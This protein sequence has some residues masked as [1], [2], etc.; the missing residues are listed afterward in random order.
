MK[1]ALCIIVVGLTVLGLTLSQSVNRDATAQETGSAAMILVSGG[2]F[3]MGN[4]RGINDVAPEHKR[5]FTNEFPVH[6]VT[7]SPYWIGK[8]EVTWPLWVRV[9][10]WAK[11]NGY[12]FGNEG[13]EFGLPQESKEPQTN[14]VDEDVPAFLEINKSTSSELPVVMINWYDMVKWCNAYSEMQGLNPCYYTSSAFRMVY[15]IG[16]KDLTPQFVNWNANGYRLPTEAEWEYA[17]K[18]GVAGAAN[19]FKYAGGDNPNDVAW[20]NANSGSATHRVGTKRPNQLGI[21]DMSGNVWEMCFDWYATYTDQAQVD[22]KG[23]G[24]GQYRV[25][26]GGSSNI[27]PDFL[28]S[29]YRT[30]N[31]PVCSVVNVGFRLVRSG[32]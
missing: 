28:R 8:Y 23:P 19:P 12:E 26:R 25:V 1:K 17:A 14:S 2:T 18:G 29:S 3:R 21:H 6:Q 5:W 27:L 9:R 7:L 22:P 4:A 16:R 11:A 20:Y 10:D 13:E 32:R 24:I 15:K 30:D 31:Y